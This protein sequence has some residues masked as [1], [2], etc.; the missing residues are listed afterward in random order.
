MHRWTSFGDGPKK[1]VYVLAENNSSGADG[2]STQV[3]SGWRLDPSERKTEERD[4]SEYACTVLICKFHSF[5]DIYKTVAFHRALPLMTVPS[6]C[7]T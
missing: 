7:C 1:N 2:A 5:L 4:N 3:R 6:F